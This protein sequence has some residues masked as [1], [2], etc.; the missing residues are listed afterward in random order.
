M[1]A[2]IADICAETADILVKIVDITPRIADILMGSCS[3][4][5]FQKRA[6]MM[7]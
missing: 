3:K 1:L 7:T 6:Y 4:G 5:G 2:E